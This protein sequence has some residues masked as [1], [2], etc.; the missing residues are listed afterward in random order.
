MEGHEKVY[1]SSDSISNTET[2][3][4]INEDFSYPDFLNSIKGSGL[5]NHMLKLIVG[6]P[7]MLIRNINQSEGLCNGTRLLV[8]NHT[9]KSRSKSIHTQDD[10]ESIRPKIPIQVPK[11]TIPGDSLLCRDNK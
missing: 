2:G 10:L 6:V 11:K 3:P 1:L 9:S 4:G 8:Y 7:I 5:P